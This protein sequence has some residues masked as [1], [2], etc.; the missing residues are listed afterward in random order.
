MSSRLASAGAFDLQLPTFE[1]KCA[2]LKAKSEYDEVE[3]EDEAI[4][5]IAN[6]VKTNVRDL[7]REYKRILTYADLK[8]VTPLEIIDSG[9]SNTASDSRKN[10]VTPRKIVETVAKYNNLSV[11]EM[12]GKSRVAN[13]KTARQIAMYLLS[14]ELSMSTTKIALEVGVKDHTT[15][16]HG[17]KKI[18]TD[19]NTNFGLREVVA[20]IREQIYV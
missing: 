2:I 4:E 15:V 18:K 8:G 10:S 14:E 19:L 11:K 16:M 7:E 17:V 5:Y 3:I 9:Y 13:I 12:C 6:A 1:D 20:E